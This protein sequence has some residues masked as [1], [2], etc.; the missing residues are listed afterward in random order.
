M[1]IKKFL[2]LKLSI[3]TL[4]VTVNACSFSEQQLTRFDY[5]VAQSNL[6]DAPTLALGV[7]GTAGLY[8][9]F[10]QNMSFPSLYKAALPA[11]LLMASPMWANHVRSLREIH[12]HNRKDKQS[13]WADAIS[14]S[15]SSWK[16]MVPPVL[17]VALVT[18]LG[19]YHNSWMRGLLGGMVIA[20]IPAW[21]ARLHMLKGQEEAGDE[22][23]HILHEASQREWT[24][25][26]SDQEQEAV[27]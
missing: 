5:A 18:S 3:I 21:Y 25:G 8:Y 7:A 4:I 19:A 24:K 11:A 17:T 27:L 9:T 13:N 20:A 12:E 22:A 23:I 26:V 2:S 10:P 14:R 1:P 16:Y 6:K 15:A